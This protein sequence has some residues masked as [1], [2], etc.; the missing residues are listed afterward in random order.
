MNS[1]KDS[2]QAGVCNI[3]EREVAIRQKLLLF[4][5]IPSVALTI[6]VHFFNGP[7]LYVGLFLAVLSTVI[8]LLEIKQDFAFCLPYSV[9]ITLRSRAI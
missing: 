1:T 2:Y 8:I 9:Y 3:G 6:L 4:A 7:V 5:L